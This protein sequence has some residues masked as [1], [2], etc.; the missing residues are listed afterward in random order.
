M[1]GFGCNG[2][3]HLAA[4]CWRTTLPLIPLLIAPTPPPTPLTSSCLRITSGSV[5]A[6]IIRPLVSLAICSAVSLS[7]P[8]VRSPVFSRALSVLI[9]PPHPQTP[10]VSAC[11]LTHLSDGVRS[12]GVPVDTVTAACDRVTYRPDL[13]GEGAPACVNICRRGHFYV[14]VKAAS[15]ETWLCVRPFARHECV[16]PLGSLFRRLF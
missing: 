15:P 11:F 5:F 12:G 16:N 2:S 7:P 1:F 3:L 9:Y 4:E 14:F 8:S 6:F 13:H 10:F